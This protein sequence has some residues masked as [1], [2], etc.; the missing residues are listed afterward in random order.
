MVGRDILLS[1]G[2]LNRP[3]LGKLIFSSEDA[4]SITEIQENSIREELAVKRDCL[5]TRKKMFFMDIPLLLKMGIRTGLIRFGW[6]RCHSST[7]PT[8]D[9]TKSLHAEEAGMRIDSQMS[10][11]ENCPMLV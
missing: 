3:K 9:E 2:E 11:A 7:T 1:D 8:L 6:W 5:A 4:A 10:L